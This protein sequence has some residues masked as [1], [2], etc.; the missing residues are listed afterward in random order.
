MNAGLVRFW[1][2]QDFTDDLFR[3]CDLAGGKGI[4]LAGMVALEVSSWEEGAENYEINCTSV[5]NIENSFNR[6][7]QDME[8]LQG[9]KLT[10]QILKMTLDAIDHKH[11]CFVHNRLSYALERDR[12][13]NKRGFEK[14][15]AMAFLLTFRWA[16]QKGYSIEDAI[17]EKMARNRERPRLHGKN[18]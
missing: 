12:K 11:A 13:D 16:A 8:L 7:P 18:Y 9:V 3:I 14:G 15:L 4:N 17:T 6:L 5:K 2:S 10:S 1:Q